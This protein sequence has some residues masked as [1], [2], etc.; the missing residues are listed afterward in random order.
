[1]KKRTS[2]GKQILIRFLFVIYVAGM[3]WLLFGQRWG[4]EIYTHNKA[5]AINL[6]PF[7]TLKMYWRILQN[8][9]DAGLL[10]HAVINLVG[11]L[12][13]FIPLGFYL[14]YLLRGMRKIFRAM[15]LLLCLI[16]MV[17]TVQYVTHLG[18]CDVDDLILNM[19]GSLIGWLIW[20]FH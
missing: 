8:S 5:S 17:E 6:Q 19:A 3:I 4:T 12:V 13:M 9:Q 2:N 7:A 10:R 1:M 15:L 14:P 18:T 16:I 20:R 11:N